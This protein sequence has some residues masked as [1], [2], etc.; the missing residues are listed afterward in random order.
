L[1][2]ER[3]REMI[4]DALAQSRHNRR[5]GETEA[6]TADARLENQEPENRQASVH[7]S[8][9]LTPLSLLLV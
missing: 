4:E 9:H 8:I 7:K 2:A 1:I 3:E 5:T 6:S